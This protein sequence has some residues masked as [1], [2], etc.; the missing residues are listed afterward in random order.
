MTTSSASVQGHCDPEFDEV[1]T[2][3]QGF[4]DSSAELGTSITVN[5]AGHDV[6]DLYGGWADFGAYSPLAAGH[7]RQYLLDNQRNHILRGA[8]AR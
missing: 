4:L 3:F 8:P 7:D 6:V 5:V 1:K 2:L